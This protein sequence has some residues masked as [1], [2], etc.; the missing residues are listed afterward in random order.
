[1]GRACLVVLLAATSVIAQTDSNTIVRRLKLR[2]NFVNGTC[3]LAARVELMGSRGPV[4][5]RKP[6]DQCEVDFSDVPSGNYRVEVS[7]LNYSETEN[8]TTSEGLADFEVQVKS[9]NRGIGGGGAL[10]SARALSIPSK[11]VKEF[12][13][14]NEL[15][16]HQEYQK[17]IQSLSRAIAIYPSYAAA[18]NNLGAVYQHLGDRAKEREALQ[19]AVS[20]DD[21]L[22]AAY[23]NLGRMDIADKDF[24]DGED[25]LRKAVSDN[26]SDP[27]ALVLLSYCQFQNRRFDEAIGTS[28]AAHPLKG[29]HSSVHLI[30]AKAFEQK[31]D[32]P[33]A[34]AELEL[35][36]K[37]MPTGERADQ[38]RKDL[39][40]LR[41]IH[42]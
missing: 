3:D 11:A 5:D 22:A 7:G 2:L 16:N 20:L 32:A 18:Y 10:V 1:M 23:L 4:A 14:S 21:H 19:K 37:E 34:I 41:A 6:D 15:M 42:Q 13:R 27:M 35:F 38:A 29:E 25:M 8:I 28:H 33:G 30:A 24:P 31:R 40:V 9:Q 17:A 36:L 12:D 39:Q 26:P